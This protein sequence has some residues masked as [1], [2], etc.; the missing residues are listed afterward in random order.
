[1]KTRKYTSV[2]YLAV[3]TCLSCYFA[4]ICYG[5]SVYTITKCA[6]GQL[7]AYDIQG[8]QIVHQIDTQID[9]GAISLALDPDSETLFVTYE[10]SNIIEMINAKTMISEQNPVLVPN[11]SNLAGIYIYAAGKNLNEAGLFNIII[12]KA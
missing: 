11:A 10:G 9:S 7:T 12:Y 6:G 8:D 2:I 1:M 5:R 4:N 3:F